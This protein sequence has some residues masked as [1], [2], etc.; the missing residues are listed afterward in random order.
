VST[1]GQPVKIDGDEREQFVLR[2]VDGMVPPEFSAPASP[3][4]SMA[5]D[6]RRLGSSRSRRHAPLRRH[7]A[8]LDLSRAWR[9]ADPRDHRPRRCAP[10]R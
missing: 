9:P 2:L 10:T 6:V 7:H 1:I 3:A 8:L 4:P 5:A